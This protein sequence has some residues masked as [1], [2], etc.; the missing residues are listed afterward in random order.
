MNTRKRKTPISVTIDTDLLERIDAVSGKMGMSRSLIIE[1]MLKRDIGQ[2]E[3]FVQDMENPVARA[4][5]AALT[6]SPKAT[7]ALL[8]L[9][10]DEFDEVQRQWIRDGLKEQIERGREREADKRGDGPEGVLA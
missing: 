5:A 4:M 3:L 8:K 1:R 9:F 2:R 7:E 6:Y 10:G